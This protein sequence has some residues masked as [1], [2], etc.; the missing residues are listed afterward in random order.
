MQRSKKLYVRITSSAVAVTMLCVTTS[1]RTLVPNDI[2][3]RVSVRGD[4]VTTGIELIYNADTGYYL[5]DASGDRYSLRKRQTWLGRNWKWI[6]ASAAGAG[7]GIALTSGGDEGGGTQEEEAPAETT[8]ASSGGGG[9]APAAPAPAAPP[10]A[11]PN[12]GAGDDELPF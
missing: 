5:N 2:R 8:V 7:L 3:P 10:A 1:C 6:I 9:G 4:S 12:A 11:D